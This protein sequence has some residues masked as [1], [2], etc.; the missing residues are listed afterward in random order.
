MKYTKRHFEN[1]A[2]ET[3]AEAAEATDANA[4]HLPLAVANAYDHMAE[5]VGKAKV[6]SG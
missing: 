6:T 1:L 2:R 3:R 4:K 5:L